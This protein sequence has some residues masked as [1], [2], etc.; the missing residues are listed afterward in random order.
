MKEKKVGLWVDSVRTIFKQTQIGR[1]SYTI[2]VYLVSFF[3]FP[4][5]ALDIINSHMANCL[6]DDYE[7]HGKIHLANWKLISMSRKDG[8]LGVPDLKIL[9]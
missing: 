6:W 8:G 7:G 4:K 2:P 1:H 3:K 5:W 9:T